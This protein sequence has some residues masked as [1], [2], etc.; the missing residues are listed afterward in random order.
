MT[1]SWQTD[2]Y[3]VL[4]DSNWQ[5]IWLQETK[6]GWQLPHSQLPDFI[7]VA[8]TA[9][10][11][12]AMAHLA[13]PLRV[14]R[15]VYEQR[16]KE[17]Q[18]LKTFF[19]LETSEPEQ[20]TG[21]Q[22]VECRHLDHFPSLPTHHKEVINQ[23]WQTGIIRSTRSRW[24]EPGWETE[25]AQWIAQQLPQTTIL[26]IEPVKGW[27]ISYVSRV[28]TTDG[29]F[30][31]KATADL[32]LFVNEG[33]VSAGLAKLFPQFIPAPHAVEPNEHWMLSADWGE[34]LGW[35]VSAEKRGHLVQQFACLQQ[36][37]VAQVPAL[38]QL[39]CLD[40]RLEKIPALLDAMF[41]SLS[42]DLS[43]LSP[44]E[45]E[46]FQNLTP[47]LKEMCRQLQSYNIP[48]TILHGDL[49]P[50]NVAQQG[51]QL[52]FFDWTDCC[53]AH[54]FLDMLTIFEEEDPQLKAHLQKS[55]LDCWQPFESSAGLQE[56]WELAEPLGIL[57]QIISYH[58][59]LF[60]L[61]PALRYGFEQAIPYWVKM[62]LK[63]MN[64]E[65]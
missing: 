33:V 38:L 43:N 28:R 18:Q 59:I 64:D 47:R 9:K 53:I 6:L 2:L 40:R 10:V 17:N 54:P 4:L 50:G 16:D 35:K 63:K 5:Q 23:V 55:Y 25:A 62:L 44:E 32:P 7:W 26:A 31:F 19:L 14:V 56:A 22:W 49:H 29:L 45:L 36:E 34:P 41:A 30:Y 65:G 51:E 46:A 20:L 27:G 24:V 39:G 58:F 52:L 37:S 13:V 42:L 15:N 3:G 12:Q 61:H 8:E 21:G 11:W 57:H 48:Q 60:Y 1:N